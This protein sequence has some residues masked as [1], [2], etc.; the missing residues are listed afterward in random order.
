MKHLFFS[1]GA[2]GQLNNKTVTGKPISDGITH[3]EKNPSKYIAMFFHK[4]DPKKPKKYQQFIYV[5]RAGTKDFSPV[6]IGKGDFKLLIHKY[7]RLPPLENDILP[8]SHRDK[9]TDNMI[10]NGR[11]IH[12]ED[13]KPILPGRGMGVL[14]APNLKIIGQVDPSDVRQGLVGDCWLLSAISTLAEYNGAV[15]KLFRNTKDIDL[16][17]FDDKPNL[18]TITLWDLKTWKEVDIVVDERLCA[19]PNAKNSHGSKKLLGAKPSA[20]DNELW[21]PYLEKA[22]VILCGGWDAVS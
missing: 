14:D 16:M 8:E 12:T 17:P 13:N 15:R 11:K 21:V 4:D 19:R 22:V 1:G 18:Y 2:V 3:F 6:N 20:N 5:H 7:N 10:Y 9:Y